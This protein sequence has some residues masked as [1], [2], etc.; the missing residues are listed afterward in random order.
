LVL[1]HSKQ[2]TNPIQI[3]KTQQSQVYWQPPLP[4]LTWSHIRVHH[5]DNHISGHRTSCHHWPALWTWQ[6]REICCTRYRG[7][8]Q[9]QH[10]QWHSV[11]S[12]DLDPVPDSD[13]IHLKGRWKHFYRCLWLSAILQLFNNKYK[14]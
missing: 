11:A 3:S 10:V 2:K 14:T 4:R 9:P 1:N 5:R 7:S 6:S 13:S 12:H 8:L